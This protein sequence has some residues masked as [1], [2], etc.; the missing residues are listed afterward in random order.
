MQRATDCDA[1]TG[2][3]IDRCNTEGVQ[4]L[5]RMM[6]GT[7]PGPTDIALLER[8]DFFFGVLPEAYTGY[9]MCSGASPDAVNKCHLNVALDSVLWK[10]DY[11]EKIMVSGT[12]LSAMI[13]TSTKESN[14]LKSLGEP[15]TA[16]TWL[17]SFGLVKPAKS[18]NSAVQTSRS[19]ALPEDTNCVALP[20]GASKAIP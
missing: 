11:L 13:D 18:T 14:T 2:D 16:G 5:L 9:P 12:D 8:R 7:R 20:N 6:Q 15:A 10:G 4:Y 1:A 17:T 3:A 19:F